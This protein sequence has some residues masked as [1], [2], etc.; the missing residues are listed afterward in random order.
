MTFNWEVN[1]ITILAICGQSIAFIVF[2]IKTHFTAKASETSAVGAHERIDK[3]STELNAAVAALTGAI[4]L[5]REQF[6]HKEDL[7]RLETN[8]GR[9]FEA[10]QKRLDSYFINK[11]GD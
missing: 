4:A 8:I 7:Q 10:L 3:L 1:T 6:V 11:A 9:Q 2:L 5:V